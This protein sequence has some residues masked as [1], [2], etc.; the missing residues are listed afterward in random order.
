M[1]ALI[2]GFGNF[3]LPLL[4]GG[5]DMAKWKNLVVYKYTKFDSSV[6]DLTMQS[7]GRKES[8]VYDSEDLHKDLFNQNNIDSLKYYLAGLFEGDGAS[9]HLDTKT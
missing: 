2:G 9:T 4:V 7:K 5:P 6:S 8:G 3:L 1:P